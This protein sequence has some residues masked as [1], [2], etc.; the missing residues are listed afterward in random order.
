MC[1]SIFT[2]LS[3]DLTKSLYVVVKT[4]ALVNIKIKKK[5]VC[6]H[7]LKFPFPWCRN[8]PNMFPSFFPI[9]L[10][11]MR[12]PNQSSLHTEQRKKEQRLK[13]GVW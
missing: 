2:F 12:D 8:V 9:A 1:C 4:F 5:L 11:V 10:F 13:K 6:I 3:L 7:M